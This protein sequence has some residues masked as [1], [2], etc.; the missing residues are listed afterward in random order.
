M[1]GLLVV[2]EQA[3]GAAYLWLRPMSDEFREG[4]TP[5]DRA[6]AFVHE[7]NGRR[8]LLVEPKPGRLVEAG[9]LPPFEAQELAELAA[10][11]VPQGAVTV[12]GGKARDLWE[13]A[14]L[15]DPWLRGNPDARVVLLAS[16]FRSRCERY[17]LR[18]VLGPEEASRIAVAAVADRRYDESN[19]WKSRTGAKEFFA[20]WVAWAYAWGQGGEHPKP[21]LWDPDDYERQLRVAAHQGT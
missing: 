19:W 5:G 6:A 16:R 3:G 2:D 15:L 14:R 17:V 21:P 8:I 7:G 20:A 1:A 4:E 13:E 18:A 9:I 11:R 10:R 12:L